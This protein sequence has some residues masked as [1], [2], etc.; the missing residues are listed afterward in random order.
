MDFEEKKEREEISGQTDASSPDMWNIE[1]AGL[2]EE[3]KK[4]NKI[5]KSTTAL[6]VAIS[7]LVTL[8]LS[9]VGTVVVMNR[10]GYNALGLSYENWNRLRWGFSVV[11]DMY[12]EEIDENELVDGALMG[13]SLALDEYS[14]YMPVDSADEFMTTVNA[15]DYC[16]VG[17]HIYSDTENN[18]VK[19]LSTLPGSPAEKA[20]LENEDIIKSVD[21]E[22]VRADVNKAS[23]LLMGEKG[24]SVSVEVERANSG[25]VEVIKITRDEIKQDVV[26][27]KII[28]ENIGYIKLTRFGINT[29]DNFVDEFNKL[30]EEG[31]EKLILDLR[32]NPGGYFN[33]A[34]QIA[35]IFLNK[36][37][38]IISTKDST[39][40]ITE[41]RASTEGNDMEVVILCNEHTASASEVLTAALRDNGRAKVIGTKTYGKGVT[42]AM[43]PY[44]DGSMFKITDTRYYTPKDVCIDKKGIKPDIKVINNEDSVDR[45][46]QL[47]TAVEELL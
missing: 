5:K 13:L 34:A 18:C 38:L 45:D 37:D 33:S 1:C 21:G 20:G 47:E 11:D 29:Y 31:M 40:H 26:K 22:E 12:Y 35:E 41:F 14:M 19:V 23:S 4:D 17:M 43:I 25:K 7:I 15:E 39:G 30:T 9:V 24:T 3:I 36:G 46:M 6:I 44:H 42:Q 27:S 2:E 28:T 32:D 16:G 8:C 10:I